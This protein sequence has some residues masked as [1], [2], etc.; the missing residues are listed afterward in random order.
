MKVEYKK[1]ITLCTLC[2]TCLLIGLLGCVQELDEQPV[3]DSSFLRAGEGEIVTIVLDVAG[4]LAEKIGEKK[5]TVENLVL[6]GP[7]NAA[8]VTCLMGMSSL[9]TLNME[10][11][12]IVGG[13]TYSSSGARIL[14]DKTVGARM[15]ESIK[16][17]TS[18]V[19]PKEAI[20]IDDEAFKTTSKLE[21]IKIFDGVISIGAFAFDQSGIKSISIPNSV[22]SIGEC[23]FWGCKELISVKLPSS[24]KI[25]NYRLFH[26]A[27]KLSSI[28]IPI[29]VTTIADDAF[30]SSGLASVTIPNSVTSIGQ[31]AFDDTKLT[32]VI[33]PNSVI[34][35]GVYAFASC[36]E[37]VSVTLP[38][39][40]DKISERMFYNNSKLENIILPESVTL[41]DQGAF[42]GCS[43][44]A[45]ISIP[46]KVTVIGN[47]AF[48]GCSSIRSISIPGKVTLIDSYAFTGCT[49]LV[50]ISIP[51]GVQTIGNGALSECVNLSSLTI[52]GSVTKVT[53]LSGGKLNNLT[54]LFWN[55]SVA[56]GDNTITIP[57]NCLVY[58]STNAA[59]PAKWKN[60]IVKGVAQ[61]ITLTDGQIFNCPKNFITNRIRFTKN[62]SKQTGSAGEA[63]GWETMVLPFK[64]E[65]IKD[66]TGGI[67]APFN[68]ATR[69]AKSFWLRKLSSSGFT[70]E[71]TMEANTPYIIAMPNNE[72][73][74][75]QY[76]ISGNVTFE[77]INTSG[78]TIK[79]TPEPTRLVGSSYS[80]LSTY[81]TISRGNSVY[82]LNKDAYGS[83]KPGSVF[84]GSLRDVNP[85]ESY[86]VTGNSLSV[87]QIDTKPRTKALS[88]DRSRSRKPSINDL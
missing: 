34:S 31:Y 10:N 59:M 16:N 12:N 74:D 23:A 81:K 79:A 17:L 36:R 52:P 67:L 72:D 62:F 11:V 19:L 9:K 13:G 68:S 83:N 64:V 51:E 35:V 69:D 26:C 38:S 49:N 77:A 40:I 25:V 33:I 53:D 71:T 44:L 1:I 85:F 2:L 43:S 87:L 55:S 50:S 22:T 27:E 73:Y 14:K 70:N 45:S 84:V 82:A 65:I 8:D 54:S 30:R 7:F 32:S 47:S 80:M 63:A 29:G 37:L 39:T 78:I 42:N 58:V 15:F 56:C 86:V 48:N 21:S 20:A 4:T 57:D 88:S 6:S 60:V 3:K 18:V 46:N 28:E 66:K 75:M 41:I 24:I 61:S 5:V 76:R